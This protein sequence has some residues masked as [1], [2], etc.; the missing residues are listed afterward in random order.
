[1]ADFNVPLESITPDQ[2][3]RLVNALNQS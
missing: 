2:G 3:E 1:L